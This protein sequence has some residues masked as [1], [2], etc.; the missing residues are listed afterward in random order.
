[1]KRIALLILILIAVIPRGFE[2]QLTNDLTSGL[3]PYDHIILSNGMTLVFSMIFEDMG[4]K[5]GIT[6]LRNSLI[7][8]LF[9]SI[10]V[11]LLCCFKEN[12]MDAYSQRPDMNANILGIGTAVISINIFN[13]IKRSRK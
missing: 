5:Y 8:S 7:R 1:M 13:L 10:C 3:N 9:S 2:F 6:F 4:E 11:Y 12:V